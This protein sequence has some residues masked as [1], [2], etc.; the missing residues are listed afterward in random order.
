[1]YRK[2]CL[3]LVLGL[4]LVGCN[5][6]STDTTNPIDPVDPV[7]PVDP[8]GEPSFGLPDGVLS[9]ED[10]N[11]SQVFDSLSGLADATS[12]EMDAGT[13]LCLADG[14]YSGDFQ[15]TFGGSGTA[16]KPIKIAAENPGKAILKGGEVAINMGGSYS[17][18]Q[19]LIF[20][21][22]EYGSN[23]I[24]TRFG[25][26]DLCSDCRISEISILNAVAQDDYGILVHI[27]GKDI[28]LDH[29]VISG[30]TVANPMISFNR[31]VDES[32][33][34]ETQLA[35]LAQGI[36]V[37]NNYIANRPP[38]DNKMYASS[39]DN[40]YEAIRTGLSATHHY[41]G[42]SFIV[43]NVFER[44]QG[45]AEV[46]SN[47]GSNN[48]IAYNTIRNSYGSLTNRHGNTNTI[49]NN[50]ILSEDY[51]FAGGLRIVDDGHTITNN[52]IESAR[53]KNTSHHGGIVLLGYDGAGDGDNGYQQV[54]NVYIANNTIVDSVNSLNI[55][56]GN[57]SN[58]PK[59]VYLVNNLIDHGIGP[60]IVQA[61]NGIM[62]DSSLAGNIFYGQTFSDDDQVS[63]GTE[64]IEFYSANL[65]IGSD[66]LYRPSDSTPDISAVS[67]YDNGDF[68]APSI[69][70]DGQT[71]SGVSSAGADE[72]L[73]SEVALQALNYADVGPNSYRLNKPEAIMLEVDVDNP[74]FDE[75]LANWT[76]SGAE[77]VTGTDAFSR[78]ASAK[79][80]GASSLSQSIALSTDTPYVVSAFVKG[81]Y[82][83]A[84]GDLVKLS[85]VESSS[86]YTWVS[87][88]FNS[89]DST[90]GTL[91]L[92][93]P[94]HVTTATDLEDGNLGEFRSNS[95]SSNVWVQ[96]EGDS[97]GLGDVGSSGD[98]A[99]TDTGSSSSGSA[100]VRFKASASNHD[101]TAT[102]GL[103]QTV[104]NIPSNTNMSYSLYYCDNK[105]DDSLSTLHYG[106]KDDSGIIIAEAFS[107]VSDLDDAPQGSVK[108]CFKQVELAFNSADNTT[109]EV[110]AFMQIDT[111]NSDPEIYASE[112]FTDDELEVRLDE[113]SLTYL[114]TPSSN[115]EGLFDD[116][117]LM[118]RED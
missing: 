77:I 92:S 72:A 111:S 31:W 55:D 47:K 60:V 37:Y 114:A 43:R 11:C 68:S 107:H 4:I 51:P 96:H 91:I 40:D 30:K 41:P 35:E 25:T 38:A 50:F 53:Y 19:G 73:D 46:I 16:D 103:S 82:Q 75:G 70:M 66:N 12:T 65:A 24:A 108:T 84:I 42:N 97:E 83:L 94:E 118:S 26:N 28:W 58:Q 89:G 76:T 63:L 48:V 113:F 29:S 14:E 27:Y 78:G 109:L 85:G 39:S 71:R 105:G 22:V 110:F 33:D 23:L 56:G 36:V 116:V 44:I 57:K 81:S 9:T 99:F 49:S 100:R 62:P 5:S 20:D 52:Y 79:L 8:S 95:G 115:S 98:S 112:Q 2:T 1:M 3:A 93:L 54:E 59:E 74:A 80:T 7:D 64:G 13:T 86:D 69:D 87:A 101:F 104:A 90:S 34:E 45:E 18:L 102:P 10:I 15:V 67:D 117:R 32:W 106:V 61:E 88:E 17:Q 21:G 6:S